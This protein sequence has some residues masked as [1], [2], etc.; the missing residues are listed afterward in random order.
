MFSPSICFFVCVQ[1]NSKY[2]T[3]L[4]ELFRQCRYWDKE[5]MVKF[6]NLYCVNDLIALAEVCAFLV[7]DLI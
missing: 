7:Y 6:Q 4:D 2:Y 1:N 5:Q 3:D